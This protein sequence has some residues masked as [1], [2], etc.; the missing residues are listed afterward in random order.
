MASASCPPEPSRITDRSACSR[1]AWPGQGDAPRRVVGVASAPIFCVVN[2]ANE[3]IVDDGGFLKARTVSSKT[4][5]A[6][7][8]LH[9]VSASTQ[10][11]LGQVGSVGVRKLVGIE[12]SDGRR[13]RLH[14]DT[15]RAAV[16]AFLQNVIERGAEAN[17]KLVANQR[18]NFNKLL[19]DPDGGPV[20]GWFCYL[21]GDEST[22][23]LV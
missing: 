12:L 15:S 3:Q 5:L 16:V 4:E 11:T 1:G 2:A 20:S 23:L 9:W 19:F 21:E 13:A 17:W 8:L 18:G 10:L 22:E 6:S 7:V 14:A